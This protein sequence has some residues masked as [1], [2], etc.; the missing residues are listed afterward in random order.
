[1][2]QTPQTKVEEPAPQATTPE[3]TSANQK[4]SQSTRPN[5]LGP[6]S[7][8]PKLQSVKQEGP[9]K[10]PDSQSTAKSQSQNPSEKKQGAEVFVKAFPRKPRD[11]YHRGQDHPRNETEQKDRSQRRPYSERSSGSNDKVCSYKSNK[12]PKVLKGFSFF[13]SSPI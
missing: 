4:A 11:S 5:A 8:G 10:Q 12:A 13:A 9:Q 3:P 2:P 1:M 7:L 6:V